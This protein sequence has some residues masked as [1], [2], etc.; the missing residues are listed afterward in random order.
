[1]D[2]FVRLYLVS[3]L[4]LSLLAVSVPVEAEPLQPVDPAFGSY[5]YQ[6][7]AEIT[8]YTLKQAR[9]GEVHPGHAVLI[10]V[11]EDFSRTKHVKLDNPRAAGTDQIPILKLNFT[12]KF[13]TGIYPYSMMTSIFS[14]VDPVHE[15]RTLKVTTTSQEWCGHTFTQLNRQGD[16]Y[17]IE[18]RSYFESEGDEELTIDAAVSEDELW[19]TIRMNP[20]N[21]PIGKIKLL[22]GTMYGRLRHVPLGLHDAEAT[23]GAIAETDGLMA[24]TLTY[25]ELGRTLTIHFQAAFPHEIE[26]WT[27][28]YRSGWGAAA[29]SLTTRATKLKSLSTDY[30][31]KN[32]LQDAGLRRDLGLE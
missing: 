12:K 10:Y 30:W 27:E 7:K 23:L 29:G 5:W 3:G 16:G 17:R 2:S 18:Q 28:S 26:A 24:Y 22:P 21:L 4:V 1:M 14:P 25:P 9:Y 15:P 13:N 19:T 11:T 31:T 32:S 6:G 20:Q 8:S